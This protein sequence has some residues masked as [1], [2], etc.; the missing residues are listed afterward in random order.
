V[1][2]SGSVGFVIIAIILVVGYLG[3][4]WVIDIPGNVAVWFVGSVL[5]VLATGAGWISG[6][7]GPAFAVGSAAGATIAIPLGLEAIAALVTVAF[8]LSVT[9][10]VIQPAFK[11]VKK[12][13]FESI[14]GLISVISIFGAE[15]LAKAANVGSPDSEILGVLNGALLYAGGVLIQ[16]PG[17]GSTV[18]GVLTLALVP[19]YLL[20]RLLTSRPIED[21]V[22]A[23]TS[24]GA[25][26][27]LALGVVVL[28][29]LASGLLAV[30]TR[31]SEL[32]PSVR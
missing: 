26:A 3:K 13:P 32:H 30:S 5:G 22:A 12:H 20:V 17:R 21:I 25:S 2:Q 11:A 9:L 19:G 29:A 18:S 4:V 14:S 7:V 8:G 16:L 27:L 10:V 23:A 1:K 31:G 24:I 28:I 15:N 6:I